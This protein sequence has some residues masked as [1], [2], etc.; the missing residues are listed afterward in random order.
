MSCS[1][2]NCSCGKGER[3]VAE[4]RSH[5][6]QLPASGGLLPKFDWSG[7]LDHLSVEV[8]IVEVRFKNRRKAFYRNISGLE[9]SGDMRIVVQSGDGH[10]LGTISLSGKAAR[11]QFDQRG[12]NKA[13]LGK[14]YRQATEQDLEMWLNAKKR[15]RDVLHESRKIA[16]D[17]GQEI[18]ISDV[19]FRGDGLKVSIFYTA[20]K[21]VVSRGLVRKFASVFGVSVEMYPTGAPK[22]DNTVIPSL[23]FYRLYRSL[24]LDPS[25]Q[26]LQVSHRRTSSGIGFQ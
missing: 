25:G 8:D 12:G 16:K 6:V 18:S 22:I 5:L 14:V 11:K 23:S 20:P 9:L 3:S 7:S 1:G 17:R 26:A 4:E 19:E 21:G 2:G 13:F 15:E 24:N 10:D